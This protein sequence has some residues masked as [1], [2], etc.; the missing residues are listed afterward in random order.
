MEG[1]AP[2]SGF[3]KFL[4]SKIAMP[5]GLILAFLVGVLLFY[6]G[7]YRSLCG[8]GF[9]LIGVLLFIIPKLFGA[10][11]L[12]LM[13]AFGIAFFLVTS[14]IGAFAVSQPAIQNNDDYASYDNNGFSDVNFTYTDGMVTATVQYETGKTVGLNFGNVSWICYFNYGVYNSTEGDNAT[15]HPMTEIEGTGEYTVTFSAGS[16]YLYGYSFTDTVGDAK[17]TSETK[18]YSDLMDSSQMTQF[19]ITW[20]M[21]YVALASIMYLMIVL[22]TTWMRKNLEKTRAQMEAEGR[23]YPQGYGR[24]KECGSVVLPGE[25]CCRKCGAYVEVPEDI[26]MKTANHFKCPGCG[27]DVLADA[28]TCPNCSRTITQEERDA[29]MPKKSGETF[30]CSDCGARVPADA[31]VC[32]K[33]GAT[34]DDDTPEEK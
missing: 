7:M 19:V 3:Q 11:D 28:E 15:V 32:P 10:K 5:I 8:F 16:G 34:F 9:L 29:A 25:T 21:Y 4:K 12:K 18:F 13:I 2:E 26:K 1:S 20:N 14:L 31:K 33:C 23:L 30:E 24:C 6:T 27:G 17:T 22:I